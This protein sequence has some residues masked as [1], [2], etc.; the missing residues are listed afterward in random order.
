MR[1]PNRKTSPPPDLCQINPAVD[2]PDSSRSGTAHERTNGRTDE[3]TN[4]RTEI[5][6]KAE[7]RQ[8]R[9]QRPHQRVRRALKRS[10][11][12]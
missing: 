9:I 6:K 4:G 1:K 2:R 7:R 8:T 3:R 11:L 12:V 10:A 5:K